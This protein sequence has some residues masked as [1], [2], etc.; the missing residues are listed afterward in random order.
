MDIF[1]TGRYL[2]ALVDEGA[3]LRFRERLVVCDGN[4]FDTLLAIPL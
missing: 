1:A 3:G 4:R 2:D